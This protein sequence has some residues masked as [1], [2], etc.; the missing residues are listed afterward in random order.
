ME[1]SDGGPAKDDAASRSRLRKRAGIPMGGAVSGQVFLERLRPRLARVG[2]DEAEQFWLAASQATPFMRPAVLSMLCAEVEW[3]LASVDGR[4]MCLWPVC[5]RADGRIEAPDFSY[6]VGPIWAP[7][8]DAG[9]MRSRVL[10]RTAVISALAT[11]LRHAHGGFAIE[12]P[13]GDHDVR[14]FRWW[15][16]DARI[17]SSLRISAQYTGQVDLATVGDDERLLAGFAKTRRQAVTRGLRRGGLEPTDWVV[18]DVERLY[19]AM[20]ERQGRP[21]LQATRVDELRGLVGLVRDG[22]GFVDA[23]ASEPGG[24]VS[25]LRLVLLGGGIACDVLSLA[26]ELARDEDL[27]ALMAFRAIRRARE[28]GARVHDFNGANSLVRGSDVHSYG[29]AAALYFAIE[30][31]PDRPS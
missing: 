3:W 11:A 6:Y 2:A 18:A 30:C 10:L 15:A 16:A 19:R 13:P 1:G 12:L 7:D 23:V 25:A 27:V 31:W 5:H 28:L 24:P 22:H 17:E 26:D 21:E 20:A 29:A 4:P 9:S 8:A 14:P